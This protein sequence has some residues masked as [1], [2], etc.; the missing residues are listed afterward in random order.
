MRAVAALEPVFVYCVA[1]VGVTGARQDLAAT[2]DAFLSRVRGATS[3]PLVVGFGISQPRHVE[4]VADLGASGVI[5]ASAL[6]DLVE[7]STDPVPAAREYLRDMK[8]ASTRGHPAPA[9]P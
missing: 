4:R 1:L 5:V 8:R 6:V 3:A 7:R 9:S 2:L